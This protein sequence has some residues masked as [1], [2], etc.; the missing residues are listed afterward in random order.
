MSHIG[1]IVCFG[2][3]IKMQSKAYFTLKCFSITG[4]KPFPI[5]MFTPMDLLQAK[6]IKH[7]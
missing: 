3:Y 6:A 5:V 2:N 1:S 4:F 7:N